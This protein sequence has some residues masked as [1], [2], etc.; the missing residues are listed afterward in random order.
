MKKTKN[1]TKRRIWFENNEDAKGYKPF[2]N[3]AVGDIPDRR[4]VIRRTW[5]F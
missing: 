3:R 2:D 1:K 5:N 4:E